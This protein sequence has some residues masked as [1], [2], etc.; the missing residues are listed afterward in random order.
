VL[1]AGARPD[2][3][4]PDGAAA[5]ECPGH[6]PLPFGFMLAEVRNIALAMFCAYNSAGKWARLVDTYIWLA[7]LLLVVQ[8]QQKNNKK[9]TITYQEIATFGLL[10][11]PKYNTP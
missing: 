11:T 5:A 9:R 6:F 10:N 8:K 4:G 7:N 3:A 1:A 2:G